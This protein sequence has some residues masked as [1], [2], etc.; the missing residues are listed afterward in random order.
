MYLKVVRVNHIPLSLTPKLVIFVRLFFGA[1]TLGLLLVGIATP[2]FAQKSD[3]GSLLKEANKLFEN[4]KYA[5]AYPLF[6]QL[7]SI[8]KGNPDITFKYGATLLYGSEK[9][10]DAI[11]YLKKASLRSTIDIRVFYTSVKGHIST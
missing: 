5:E 6:T 3:K 9:K 8:Q 10:A 4:G 7:L 2:G 11:S 1:V